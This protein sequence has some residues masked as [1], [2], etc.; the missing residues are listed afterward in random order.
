MC[1]SACVRASVLQTAVGQVEMYPSSRC[2]AVVRFV[3]SCCSLHASPLL[4]LRGRLWFTAHD[5]FL[6]PASAPSISPGM[7]TLKLHITHIRISRRHNSAT[8]GLGEITKAHV[9]AL[10]RGSDCHVSLSEQ[11]QYIYLSHGRGVIKFKQVL[12]FSEDA[13]WGCNQF[14]PWKPMNRFLISMLF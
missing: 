11:P 2:V 12:S 9:T 4:L 14:V 1:H 5:S 13:F 10:Q 7:Q 8:A 3:C 6:S